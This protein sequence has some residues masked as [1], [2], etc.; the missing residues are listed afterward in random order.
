MIELQNIDVVFAQGTL[1]ENKVLADFNLQ[2]ATGEFVTVIGGNGA[3]KSTLLNLIAGDIKP[4]S[5]TIS[6]DSEDVTSLCTTSRAKHIAKVFQDPMMG[7]CSALTIEENLSL[8]CMR[9]KSRSFKLAITN[10]IREEFRAKLAQVNMGLENRMYEQVSLLSGGQRQVLS[11]IMAT[12]VPAKLLLLDE[13][14]AALD[15]KMARTVLELTKKL[16][17]EQKLTTLMITHSMS[18]ALAFGDRTIMMYHGKII[19]DMQ[20]ED[21]RVLDPSHLLEFFDL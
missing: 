11:L 13:H 15:P 6:I 9:G 17:I 20:G 21:R 5:G 18:Q 4:A 8:A 7:T 1:L 14:T 2:V 16:V 19:R 10:H 3:G 12:M